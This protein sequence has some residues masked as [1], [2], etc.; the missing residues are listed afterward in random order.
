MTLAEVPLPAVRGAVADGATVPAAVRAHVGAL[1]VRDLLDVDAR[2]RAHLHG[3][4][5]AL[6]PLLT[7]PAVTDVL[8][9]D[10]VVWVDRGRGLERAAVDLGSPDEVRALAVRL[11]AACGQRLDDASPIVDGS[12]PD[13]TRLHAVLAP[14]SGDGT[15]ISLRTQRPRAFTLDALARA[16]TV[17]AGVEVV[18][19][20]MVAARA[21]VLVSGAT[22]T[23]KTTLLA[24]VLGLVG[25]EERIVVIEEVTELRPA[26]PHVVHLQVRHPN[27]QRAGAV[28]M[29]ELVR[30]AMRMRPDRL[31]LGEC[32]GPEVRE[33]LG[34]LNTGHDGGWATIH[35]NASADVPSRLVALGALAG[36]DAPTVAAQACSALDAVVHLR[37]R[38]QHRQVAEV[39]VLDRAGAELA[40][41]LAL[42][43][44]DDGAV[45]AGPAWPQLAARLGLP[46]PPSRA[47]LA[48]GRH[49]AR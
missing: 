9:N 19:R 32:R 36:L 28:P 47:E 5:E 27:V 10:G 1:G 48:A 16:G 38:G 4:G 20:A 44:D 42:D 15:L 31:V 17:P 3:V 29:S 33:V 45:N 8:V 21:N 13:G 46:V 18:L 35:A 14:V 41:R 39:A 23:G 37:R 43:V 2:L 12:L 11:A 25:P 22:G 7:A 30:A 6:Q 49:R 40:C 24:A 34:G 26:H